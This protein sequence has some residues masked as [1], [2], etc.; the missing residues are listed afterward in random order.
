M[1][2]R[3]LLALLL[4]IFVCPG[5][6]HLLLREYK[7][8]IILIGIS[9]LILIA[10]SAYLAA[11]VDINTFALLDFKAK[12]ENIA[13]LVLEKKD[14]LNYFMVPYLLAWT[15]AIADIAWNAFG[16]LKNATGKK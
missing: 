14:E 3:Y 2:F 5:I 6:G 15:Y 10:M 13:K 8:A 7:K 4:T 12:E 1:F 11:Y 9:V 16:A